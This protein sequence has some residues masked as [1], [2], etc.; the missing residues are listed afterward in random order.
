LRLREYCHQS[1]IADR[2]PRPVIP[3]E[4]RELNKRVVEALANQYHW[5]E[6]EKGPSPRIWMYRK[7]SWAIEDQEQ[8]VGL[9][10]QPMG[11]KGL[12]AID[13]VGSPMASAVETLLKDRLNQIINIRNTALENYLV[14]TQPCETKEGK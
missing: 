3:G 6:Q 12:E 10:Y 5:M 2:I 4:K 9:I 13:N 8:D 14:T 1:G 7:A 11:R